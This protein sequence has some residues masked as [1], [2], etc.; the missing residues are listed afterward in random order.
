MKSQPAAIDEHFAAQFE[1]AR[2]EFETWRHSRTS[3]SRIPENLWIL[4]ADLAKECG[5]FQ[6]ARELHLNYCTLRNRM[7]SKGSRIV[8]S[9]PALMGFVE[10]VPPP[11]AACFSECTVEIERRKGTKIR[12]HLKSREA[13]DL[14][15][16]GAAFLRARA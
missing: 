14:G 16:I 1:S 4:A 13:P 8:R 7:D 12:I 6:T 3:R 10:V 15:E 9:K 5:V 2:R 11:P